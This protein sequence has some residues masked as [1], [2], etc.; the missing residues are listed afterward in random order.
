MNG[1]DCIGVVIEHLELNANGLSNVIGI[2]NYY[3]QEL[4]RVNDVSIVGIGAGGIG[5]DLSAGGDNSG[6]Y[7]N[8]YVGGNGGCARIN[9]V[10]DA[11]VFHVIAINVMLLDD[12]RLAVEV[13]VAHI[14]VDIVKLFVRILGA[15][16]SG[17]SKIEDLH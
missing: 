2:A 3:S 12:H 14:S 5:L 4:S 13:T 10:E 7:T 8:I 16:K 6:P 17:G 11:V 15:D 1:P 9:G